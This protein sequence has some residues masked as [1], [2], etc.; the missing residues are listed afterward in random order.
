MP[1]SI[2]QDQ[3]LYEYG[4]EDNFDIEKWKQLT[5]AAAELKKQGNPQ[6]KLYDEMSKEYWDKGHEGSGSLMTPGFQGTS[7]WADEIQSGLGA[8]YGVAADAL[9]G[10]K[11]YSGLPEAGSDFLNR[12]KTLQEDSAVKRELGQF[13]Y[14]KSSKIMQGV[15]TT[16]EMVLPGPKL[17]GVDI[18]KF[19]G[20]TALNAIEKTP[21]LNKLPSVTGLVNKNKLAN[22]A[23]ES[24]GGLVNAFPQGFVRGMG[25]SESNLLDDPLD[26][27]KD[28]YKEAEQS[29]VIAS[30]TGLITG[31]GTR[32]L[33][34]AMTENVL[35]KYKAKMYKALE[36][37]FGF[38]QET[39]QRMDADGDLQALMD[40]LKKE[41]VSNMTID[42]GLF[43]IDEKLTKKNNEYDRAMEAL[44]PVNNLFGAVPLSQLRDKARAFVSD[45]A[46]MTKIEAE[47]N[48][49]IGTPQTGKH[50]KIWFNPI[51][52]ENEL[53]AQGLREFR[54]Q[55]DAKTKKYADPLSPKHDDFQALDKLRKVVKEEFLNTAEQAKIAS[56]PGGS[57]G[58]TNQQIHNFDFKGEAEDISKLI[59]A[60]N[61]LDVGV[62]K[63]AS[64]MAESPNYLERAVSLIVPGSLNWKLRTTAGSMTGA[65]TDMLSMSGWGEKVSR[66]GGPGYWDQFGLQSPR[67][68]LTMPKF[69][70]DD[71]DS[72]EI[73]DILEAAKD[74]EIPGLKE[75]IEKKKKADEEEEEK[76]KKRLK[77][78]N[79]DVSSSSGNR[80][81]EESTSE[82]LKSDSAA[83]FRLLDKD[84]FNF[85]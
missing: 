3:S 31:Y 43:K 18:S 65:P 33:N 24:V 16:A 78:S 85:S 44:D 64:Q 47:L 1:E 82:W 69:L 17:P 35:T 73:K 40:T 49:Y 38:S 75:M 22:M 23:S 52:K 68:V 25:R 28:A 4:G 26:V 67:T 20:K 41:K 14:P 8:G 12:Y 6:W 83:G 66:L 80:W 34:P 72:K 11:K 77:G 2:Y 54:Q 60:K 27:L 57:L 84:E 63:K 74:V 30:G 32:A 36:K 71:P 37:N 9:T 7:P 19:A 59:T 13:L 29:A 55:L 62:M 76:R 42:K 58:I 53:T 48:N 10:K 81:K 70:A 21:L 50:P 61:V 39:I 45:Q 46:E 5:V 79:Y 15:G 51:L 56:A